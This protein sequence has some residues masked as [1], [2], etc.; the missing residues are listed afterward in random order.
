M[1]DLACV[2]VAIV[3][4]IIKNL[5]DTPLTDRVLYADKTTLMPGGEAVN[6]SV[7]ASKL[8]LN[9]KIICCMGKDYAADILMAELKA[10]NV[11]TSDII[12]NNKIITPVAAIFTDDCGN[13]RSVTTD[14]HTYNFH[15]ERY[16]DALNNTKAVSIGS[17]FRAPF[18]D[19]EIIFNFVKSAKEKGLPVYADTKMPNANKIGLRDIRDSLPYIDYIFPNEDEAKHYSG[20]SDIESI[21]DEFLKYGVSNV[22]IKLGSKGCFLKNKDGSIHLD[23]YKV[24]A[25]D[26]T[27]AGDNFIAGFIAAKNRNENDADAL[28]FAN[29]CGAV[30]TEKIGATAAL[31]SYDQIKK[32]MNK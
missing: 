5:N 21:A 2:G 4:C 27:G 6:Q 8:G 23:G 19:P 14:A 11:D 7:T 1:F 17:L 29:A 30:S 24:K 26:A 9:T 15:P 16:A 20:R 12:T 3:D 13:R 28:V 31:K 22:I 32:F 18:N 10:S 25:V